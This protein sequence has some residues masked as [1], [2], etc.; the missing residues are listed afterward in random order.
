MFSAERFQTIVAECDDDAGGQPLDVPFR[1]SNHAPRLIQLTVT[2]SDLI[3]A[4]KASCEKL[5]SFK[6]GAERCFAADWKFFDAI[7]Y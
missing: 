3:L 5:L 4:R 2:P 7:C 6:E 1:R